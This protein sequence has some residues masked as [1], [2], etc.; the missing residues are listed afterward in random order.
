MQETKVE[1]SKFPVDVF[2][3]RGYHV[4]FRGRKQYNGVAI[5]SFRKPDDVCYGLPD[6][7]SPDDDRLLYVRFGDLFVLN[8]Y[9]P[10]GRDR[11]SEHFTYKLNWFARLGQFIRRTWSSTDRLIWCGDLNVAPEAIDVYDPKRLLG[12]VCFNPDV[13][14]AYEQVCAWGLKDVFRKHHP[15]EEKQYTFYDYRANTKARGLG[16]RIDHILA[17]DPLYRLSRSCDIDL[18]PRQ[19]ERPSDHTVLYA[20]FYEE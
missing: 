11:D 16:W 8:T 17:A 6:G 20:E 19:A 18:E 1:D 7:E 15:G 13:W 12:H 9:V 3:E 2:L 14:S 5:A 10:Q 4:S